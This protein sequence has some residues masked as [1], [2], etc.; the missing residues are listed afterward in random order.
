MPI[1]KLFYKYILS[2]LFTLHSTNS[3]LTSYQTLQ[4]Y[5]KRILLCSNI[6]MNVDMNKLHKSSTKLKT[7]SKYNII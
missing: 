6:F 1:L 3:I 4:N 2:K 5:C 7:I